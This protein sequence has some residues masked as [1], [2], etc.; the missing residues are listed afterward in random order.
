MLPLRNAHL[1]S[2]CL[3]LTE[4]DGHGHCSACGSSA[5]LLLSR[6][7]PVHEDSIRLIAHHGYGNP[8]LIVLQSP[9]T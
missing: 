2:D 6:I 5:I 4:T 7:I 3:F 1:C 8:R 9:R